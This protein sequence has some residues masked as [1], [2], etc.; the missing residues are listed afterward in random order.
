M[1]FVALGV[2]VAIIL[3]AT[4]Y[5]TKKSETSFDFLAGNGKIN[6]LPMA[7]SISATWIWAPALFVSAEKA[8]D[9][10]IVGAFWFIAP[11]VFTILFFIP[12]AIKIRKEMP[13]GYTLS[14]YM[15][16]K[17]TPRVRKAY[18][19]QLG[20]LALLS[21]VV[22]LLAGGKVL[23]MMIDLPFWL[24]TLALGLFAFIYSKDAGI[25]A[26]V[27]T[28]AVQMVMILLASIIFVPWALKLNGM[29]SLKAGLGG[30]TGEFNS[31]FD[32]NGVAIML[33]YGIPTAIGLMSGPFGDQN[34]WQRAFSVK[35]EDVGK[36]LGLGAFFFAIVPIS[37]AVLGFIAA[38]VGFVPN[39]K[40]IVNLELVASILPTWAIWVFMFMLLS[41]LLSTIDSNLCSFASLVHTEKQNSIQ[42]S[43][44]Y[45]LGLV[46]VATVLANI[47]G[48]SVFHLFLIYGI[49]RAITLLI[50]AGTLLGYKFNEAGIFYGIVISFVISLP[51]FVYGSLVNST[52][53]KLAGSISAPLLT[54]LVA[55]AITQYKKLQ[56]KN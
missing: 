27:I 34:F 32:A 17:Y 29:E 6:M 22:Q 33:A 50:T 37:M 11:N 9:N 43:K 14:G 38:G 54:F 31:L 21:T 30:F 25:K 28:D 24:T 42:S 23:S 49:L 48:L 10:G 52:A 2:Y 5:L 45:M 1:I 13:Y 55:V 3:L 20:A 8:Y 7:L 12:F 47:P 40:G 39:D 19:F 51:I 56:Y 46:L 4:K 44:Y 26:S 15:D 18:T 16:M 53:F 36:S 35:K 41:G